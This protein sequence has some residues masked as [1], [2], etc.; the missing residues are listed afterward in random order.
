MTE[1]F[2][3]KLI[4]E[5]FIF[6]FCCERHQLKIQ[7]AANDYDDDDGDWGRIFYQLHREQKKP[8]KTVGSHKIWFCHHFYKTKYESTTM[9]N[10]IIKFPFHRISRN[11]PIL[12]TF[13]QSTARREFTHLLLSKWFRSTNGQPKTCTFDR[14]K[15]FFLLCGCGSAVCVQTEHLSIL[16]L[17]SIY[18]NYLDSAWTVS[19]VLFRCLSAAQ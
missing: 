2:I 1:Q 5:R 16:L 4:K 14:R 11:S 15:C 3:L 12:S 10:E 17:L 9:L 7:C 19:K 8:F 13:S 18:S 6:I